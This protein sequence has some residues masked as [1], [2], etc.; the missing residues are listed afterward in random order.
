[1]TVQLPNPPADVAQTLA[2]RVR[3]AQLLADADLLPP[4]YR[5]RP[6]NVLLAWEYAQAL[7]LPL[8]TALTEV[9]VI[10]GKPVVSAHLMASLARRAGHR[11]RTSTT[12]DDGSPVVSCEIVRGDDR[13]FPFVAIWDMARAERAG[14]IGK[15]NWKQYPEAMLR[16]RAIAECVREACPEVLAGAYDPDELAGPAPVGVDPAT[17]EI[18]P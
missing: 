2:A 4:A 3:F 16:A 6:A 12:Y 10:A 15:D 17:G 5:K 18:T 7:D 13:E 11:V 9:H 14:L 8:A 1:M